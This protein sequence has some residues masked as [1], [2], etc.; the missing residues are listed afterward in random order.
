M[1]EG[2]V[3]HRLTRRPFGRR[4]LWLL[5]AGLCG[6][7]LACLARVDEHPEDGRRPDGPDA[8]T[9]LDVPSEVAT[10]V[11]VAPDTPSPVPLRVP[12]AE[13]AEPPAVVEI[14]GNVGEPC[15]FSGRVVDERGHPVEGAVV[16][17]LPDVRTLRA[18]GIWF[19]INEV[20]RFTAEQQA[21][22]ARGS[23]D[24]EG[25]FRFDARFVVASNPNASE[26]VWTR[27]PSLVVVHPGYALRAHLCSGFNGGD[28]DSGDIAIEPG[29][30]LVGRVVDERGRPISSAHIWPIQDGLIRPVSATT[31][32]DRGSARLP[33]QFLGA[34]SDANGHFAIEG[35]WWGGVRGWATAPQHL[36]A[37]LQVSVVASETTD[38]GDI[39]LRGG[40]RIVGR[41]VDG[42]SRPVAGARVHAHELSA[43][44]RWELKWGNIDPAASALS[45]LRRTAQAPVSTDANGDFELRGVSDT[46]VQILVDADGFDLALLPEASPDQ[47][48]LTIA[49]VPEA[50][51]VVD[52]VDQ[53]TGKPLT[54]ATV[55]ACRYTYFSGSADLRVEPIAGRD[56]AFTVHQVRGGSTA[57]RVECPGRAPALLDLHEVT[58]GGIDQRTVSLGRSAR[59]AGRII[60][61]QG[62]PVRGVQVFVRAAE[63]QVDAVSP[64]AAATGAD[65]LFAFDGLAETRWQLIINTDRYLEPHPPAE[66]EAQAGR[67]VTVPDIMLVRGGLLTGHLRDR[68]GLPV[69]GR[70]LV[71]TRGVDGG[72]SHDSR[73]DVQGRFEFGALQPGNWA[74]FE[75]RNPGA[76]LGGAYVGWHDTVELDLVVPACALLRGW[77]T[78]ELAAV[79]DGMVVAL[80]ST[81]ATDGRVIT[82]QVAAAATRPDG[83]W[84]LALQPG[85]YELVAFAADPPR[86]RSRPARVEVEW[87]EQVDVELPFLGETLEVLVRNGRSG[88]PIEGAV[89]SL[90]SRTGYDQPWDLRK[91][92]WPQSDAD[93]RVSLRNVSPG[94]H[95]IRCAA[96]GWPNAELEVEVPAA[97]PAGVVFDLVAPGTV[98]GVVHLRPS[99]ELP[100]GAFVQAL[101]L[102]DQ[103]I[104]MAEITADGRFSLA[105][106]PAGVC[107]IVVQRFVETGGFEMIAETTVTVAS[108]ETRAVELTL[109]E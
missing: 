97:D 9:T 65:G 84:E 25:R 55:S 75:Q 29:C 47:D 16:V 13:G 87:G 46:A 11:A 40:G 79:S 104:C 60:D 8:A 12:A 106:L 78:D 35:L 69:S 62:R 18:M 42:G 15:R 102:S 2:M 99:G 33:E 6:A 98:E 21:R 107:R 14:E 39:V 64:E 82:A 108:G 26:W 45:C 73:T 41:V 51:L 81:T 109:N 67:S 10:P 63:P 103:V 37:E 93:G 88:E 74:V 100:T 44:E 77:L 58:P 28:Y 30:R 76:P 70:E 38:Y 4:A 50:Q 85:G 90:P 53:A 52:V 68:E 92:C 54:E 31:R 17:H 22:F 32:D 49:L 94:Q 19:D 59:V 96:N 56:G 101:H 66:F 105:Q 89:V 1:L 34:S 36:A 80:Q 86:G 72:D 3:T 95:V 43:E 71:A 27:D 5:A 83:G 48:S 91:R 61:R 57:V 7:V 20:M 23:S 24:S